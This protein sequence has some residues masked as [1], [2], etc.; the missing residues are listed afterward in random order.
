MPVLGWRIHFTRRTFSMPQHPRPLLE[1]LSRTE[2]AEFL[3]E[4]DIPDFLPF[5]IAP[6]GSYDIELN[7]YFMRAAIS[8]GPENTAKATAYDLKVFFTFLW[9]NRAPA[10]TRGWR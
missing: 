1:G 4:N 6:D 10:G 3:D 9:N 2:V 7:G 8:A 5:L